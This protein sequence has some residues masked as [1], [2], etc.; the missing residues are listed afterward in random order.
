MLKIVAP[1]AADVAQLC[2]RFYKPLL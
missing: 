1:A 2:E